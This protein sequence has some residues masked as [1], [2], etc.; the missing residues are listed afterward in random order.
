MSGHGSRPGAPRAEVG[1]QSANAG[2]AALTD[3][4]NRF[5]INLDTASGPGHISHFVPEVVSVAL[6]S[7]ALRRASAK[8]LQ[9]FRR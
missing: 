1:T 4:R 2:S 6:V 3:L 5:S 8:D 7:R 9:C